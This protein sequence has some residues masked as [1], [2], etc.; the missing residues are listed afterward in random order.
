M[1][2]LQGALEITAQTVIQAVPGAV[3]CDLEDEAVV[4][5]DGTYFTLN[6]LGAEVWRLMERPRR[7][8]EVRDWILREYDVEAE[9]CEADLRAWL[10][11]MRD[12]GLVKL[13]EEKGV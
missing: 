1:A 3:S 10:C 9:R 12:R 2:G 5:H 13:L 7:F 8:A 6:R 4:L 11:E